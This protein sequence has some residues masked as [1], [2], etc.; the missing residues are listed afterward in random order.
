MAKIP[1]DKR[2]RIAKGVNPTVRG[3][4]DAGGFFAPGQPMRPV[5]PD[6]QRGRAFDYRTGRNITVQPRSDED[7]G[8][9]FAELRMLSR[10]HD[11]TRLLI[12]TRKDQM[13]AIDWTIK[14]IEEM[15]GDAIPSE[16]LN[17]IQATEKFLEKPDGKTLFGT[18]LRSLL[19][20]VLAIDAPTVYVND[21]RVGDTR[22]E[23]LDGATIKRVV[24][25]NGRTPEPPDVAFQQVIK[26]V[27]A[28]DFSSDELIYMPR[29][30]LTDRM[31]GYSPVEQIIITVNIAL[32]KQWSQLQFYT[33]GNVPDALISVPK[34]WTP[35]QIATYQQMWDEYFEGNTGA[36]RRAKFVPGEAKITQTKE[37]IL[38]NDFDE[39]LARVCCYAF[40]ISPQAFTK[41]MNRATAATAKQASEEEGLAPLLRWAKQYM[42]V[43]IQEHLGQYDLEFSWADRESV[44]PD[45]Q[46]QIADRKVRSGRATIN[47]TRAEEGKEPIPGGDTAMIYMGPAPTPVAMAAEGPPPPPDGQG[48]PGDDEGKPGG[49]KPPPGEDDK[50]P[51]PHGKPGEGPHLQNVRRKG[52]EG[53]PPAFL[54][55]TKNA[56]LFI[57]RPVLNAIEIVAWAKD[58]G[59]RT[60]LVPEDMHVTVMWSEN[61]VDWN[62]M[63]KSVDTITVRG[64]T[65]EVH[66]LGDKGAVVLRFDS[67][68]LQLRWSSLCEAGCEWQYDSYRPHISISYNTE[69]V[70]LAAIE[71]YQGLIKLGPEVFKEPKKDWHGDI[72]EAATRFPARAL[73]N[74]NKWDNY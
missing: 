17:R 14:P 52:F 5:A 59:F 71:P 19:E 28:W 4:D 6:N 3:A 61:P 39:W 35:V 58:Q 22:F 45:I 72:K 67:A 50:E 38:K 47:E 60:T 51:E 24:N 29:N 69:G 9:S 43:I 73:V 1:Y 63:G 34:E 11:I 68:S 15:K 20:D 30:V 21:T 41:Q 64:G 2:A 10:T 49:G 65:R 31:Y 53:R 7:Y 23:V 25:I 26:G 13:E 27:A 37:A 70:D 56:P 57:K 8:P 18:W 32:R 36:R 55:K 74:R 44:D 54:K 42:D 33:E 12:E 46:D 66:P 62:A 40:S 48:E 16:M